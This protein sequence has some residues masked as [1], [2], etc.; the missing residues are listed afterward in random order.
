MLQRTFEPPEVKHERLFLISVLGF[1]V[2]L[3]GIFAFSHGHAH[4]GMCSMIP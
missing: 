2:N 4:G 1:I 3:I